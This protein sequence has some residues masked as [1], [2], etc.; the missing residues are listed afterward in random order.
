MIAWLATGPPHDRFRNLAGLA[1]L[2]HHPPQNEG[3]ASTY[4]VDDRQELIGIPQIRQNDPLGR[5]GANEVE[6]LARYI[7]GLPFAVEV[8]SPPEVR[9]ALRALG[10]R[11]QESNRA[12]PPLGA[13]A[14]TSPRRRFKLPTCLHTLQYR[15]PRTTWCRSRHPK[16]RYGALPDGVSS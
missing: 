9:A 14:R 10:R 6:W 12:R 16:S 7:A 1:L 4:L 11:L 5:V 3:L 13:M 2:E 15:D 8:R